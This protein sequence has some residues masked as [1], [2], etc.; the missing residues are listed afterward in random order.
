M[1][2]IP[3]QKSRCD[4]FNSIAPLSWAKLRMLAQYVQPRAAEALNSLRVDVAQE[5]LNRER[6]SSA[7]TFEAVAPP[8]SGKRQTP[9][10]GFPAPLALGSSYLNGSF[11]C[12]YI[13]VSI[14]DLMSTQSRAAM[15]L[16]QVSSMVAIALIG[17]A[18]TI[19]DEIAI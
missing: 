9:H 11:I 19:A 4:N 17:F 6:S 10:L 2:T 8:T 15:V 7:S 12:Q 13:G 1:I 3:R 16:D 14:R 18:A 5:L